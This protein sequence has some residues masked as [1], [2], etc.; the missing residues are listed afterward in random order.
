MRFPS[1]LRCAIY[2]ALAW[3]SLGAAAADTVSS[4]RHDFR[5]VTVAEGLEHPW[6]LAFLPNGDMLVTERPGRLRII[7]D[8]K[9]DP[10]PL[11]GLLSGPEPA[12]VRCR[13]TPFSLLSS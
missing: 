13:G 5:L 12:Q 7:R 4:E 11:S 10:E 8:G 3:C 6:G 2:A 9:L 1:V